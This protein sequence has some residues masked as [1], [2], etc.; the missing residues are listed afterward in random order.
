[1]DAAG[2]AARERDRALECRR[3][4]AARDLAL[5]AAGE[6]YPLVAAQHAAAFEHEADELPREARAPDGPERLASD[7]RSEE[8]TSELQSRVDLVCRL[9]LEKKKK[10]TA[11]QCHEHI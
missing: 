1:M 2:G 11:C 5:A 9:L 8:H 3:E 10:S 6:E 7:E 4:R